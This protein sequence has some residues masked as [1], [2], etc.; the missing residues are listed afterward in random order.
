MIS[1]SFGCPVAFGKPYEMSLYHGMCRDSYAS[2]SLYVV[3]DIFYRR[4]GV[5][6]GFQESQIIYLDLRPPTVFF[7]T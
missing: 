6:M 7:P 4:E 1:L 3:I 2:S 5:C